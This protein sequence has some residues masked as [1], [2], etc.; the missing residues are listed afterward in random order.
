WHRGYSLGGLLR[1]IDLAEGDLLVTLNQTIDLLQ[2][3]QGAIG[4]VLDA[5]DLWR[6]VKPET[7][8]GRWM[9]TMRERLERLRPL[10]D[11]GWRGMLRGSVAQSRA[12]PSMTAAARPTTPASDLPPIPMA[13]D[14]DPE[15]ARSDR[16]ELGTPPA[17]MPPA[18]QQVDPSEPAGPATA[19]PPQRQPSD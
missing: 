4:Q 9:G 14:E 1:R 13:E 7:R 12:I 8:F 6:D 18:G 10:V 3:V 5:R 19:H 17:E 11:A 16:V 15:M 2:Q